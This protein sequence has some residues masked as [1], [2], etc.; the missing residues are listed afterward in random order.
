MTESERNAVWAVQ[1]T[2]LAR[3]DAVC[4][5]HGLAYF[6]G[7][8]TL[9]GAVRH[10]GYIPWD[11]DIDLFMLRADY[12]RLVA[13]GAAFSPP[14]FLQTAYNDVSYSRGHAQLRLDGTTAILAGERGHYRFHQGIFIDIFPLDFVPDDPAEQAA[15]RRRLAR[16]NKWLAATVRYPGSP[17]KTPLK[18]ALHHLLSSIPYRWIFRKMEGECKRYKNTSRVALLSFD[19]GSDRWVMPADAFAGAVYWPFEDAKI[20]IPVGFDEVLTAAYG[21]WRTPRKEPTYHEGV[22]YDPH[23]DW[24]EYV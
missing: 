11:D 1:L 22:F 6:A 13:V 5:R 10:Q 21:D 12:D 9:L 18:T 23:R 15:Q 14:F 3:F 7:G 8:G 19:P 20:P 17:H 2:L 4:R 16:W 24:R